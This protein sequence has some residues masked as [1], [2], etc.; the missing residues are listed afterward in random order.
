MHQL[1]SRPEVIFDPDP[2]VIKLKTLIRTKDLKPST[3]PGLQ[4][5]AVRR[6]Y[7]KSSV[8]NAAATYYKDNRAVLE[9]IREKYCIPEAVIVSILMIETN[10]GRNTGKRRAFNVLA[11]MAR[12]RD[13]DAVSDFLKAELAEPDTA[14]YAQRRCRE[15]S[16]WA[17]N[18]LKSLLIY[19][20]KNRIDPLSISGS[21]YG[22]IG[23]CQFMPSNVFLYG[24]D[25]DEKGHI[26][27]F[28]RRD[29]LFSIGNY[30]RMNGWTCRMAPAARHKVI[31]SYNHS[32]I[33]ANTVLAVADRLQGNIRASKKRAGRLNR[34]G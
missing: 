3:S 23:L 26:D 11:S 15:K 7:L 32:Q 17:Y 31:L 1:F 21:I 4:T 29:A 33:Y 9:R 10:L 19:A 6:Q 20:Q 13:V 18:E 24:V 30:L 27:L 8:I 22:A 14:A 34:E 28:S 25:T 2:M 16:E 12:C 5:K